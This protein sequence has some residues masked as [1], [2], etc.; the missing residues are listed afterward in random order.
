M[1]KTHKILIGGSRQSI[2]DLAKTYRV[3][4]LV[5]QMRSF[6]ELR[7]EVMSFY[8]TGYLGQVLLCDAF[9]FREQHFG[10]FLKLLESADFKGVIWFHNKPLSGYPFT[11][12]SRCEHEVLYHFNIEMTRAYL[13]QHG[14][15]GLLSHM[16]ALMHYPIDEAVQL[17]SRKEG[18]TDLLL[19]LDSKGNQFL[20]FN[21]I[22]NVDKYYLYLFYEWLSYGLIFTHEELDRC[23]FL[24]QE[25]FLDY[26]KDLTFSFIPDDERARRAFVF[27]LG[28]KGYVA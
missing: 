2:D 14:K 19:A 18:F 27:M 28:Y 11:I 3:A 1:S 17:L 8:V 15:E 7:E 12:R 5:P 13:K 26:L 22:K 6:E 10:L 4:L 23:P 25:K 9:S 16:G 24:R 20:Y 21:K